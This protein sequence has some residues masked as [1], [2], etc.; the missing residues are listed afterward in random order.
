[1]RAPVLWW[2]VLLSGQLLAPSYA[3]YSI[4]AVLFELISAAL[5]SEHLQACRIQWLPE[6][7]GGWVC[8]LLPTE[9]LPD[10]CTMGKPSVPCVV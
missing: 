10:V 8:I 9:A 7:R 6:L 2:L 4:P 3:A 5:H 1:M